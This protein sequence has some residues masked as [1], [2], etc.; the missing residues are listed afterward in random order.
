MISHYQYGVA[1]LEEKARMELMGY[2]TSDMAFDFL[3]TKN[4]LGYVCF[5]FGLSNDRRLG[6]NRGP[7]FPNDQ[8]KIKHGPSSSRL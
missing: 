6:S 3:R 8:P 4:T 7:G 1:T 2:L 5:R